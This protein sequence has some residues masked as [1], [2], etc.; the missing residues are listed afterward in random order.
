MMTMM[1]MMMTMSMMM[2]MMMM[3]MINIPHSARVLIVTSTRA[4]SPPWMAAAPRGLH[5]WYLKKFFEWIIGSFV[6]DYPMDNCDYLMDY[7]NGLFCG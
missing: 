4:Q 7:L 3:I 2:L 1:M 6:D 5:D